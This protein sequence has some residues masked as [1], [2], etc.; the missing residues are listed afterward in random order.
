MKEKSIDDILH[1]IKLSFGNKNYIKR[2]ATSRV[3]WL[4]EDISIVIEGIL[5]TLR[6]TKE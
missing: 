3:R 6:D 1:R 2:V 5:K 4:E